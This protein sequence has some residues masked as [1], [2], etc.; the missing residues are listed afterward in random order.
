MSEVALSSSLDASVLGCDTKLTFNFWN[1]KLNKP[2]QTFKI[3]SAAVAIS[4]RTSFEQTVQAAKGKIV[5]TTAEGRGLIQTEE[6][7]LVYFDRTVL[8]QVYHPA[9]KSSAATIIKW[10]SIKFSK[11]P[12]EIL[13]Y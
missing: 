2:N 4:S 11:R 10:P 8:A 9:K 7:Q 6:N 3:F 1:N 13:R 5:N 12:G